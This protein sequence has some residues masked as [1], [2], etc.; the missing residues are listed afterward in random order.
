[1]ILVSVI[2]RSSFESSYLYESPEKHHSFEYH[3]EDP[4]WWTDTQSQIDCNK[5]PTSVISSSSKRLKA[6]FLRTMIMAKTARTPTPFH[7]YVIFLKCQWKMHYYLFSEDMAYIP[8]PGTGFYCN[9]AIHTYSS[10]CTIATGIDD[11]GTCVPVHVYIHVYTCTRVRTRIAILYRYWYNTITR[12]V[13]VYVHVYCTHVLQYS[14][15][16]YVPV[17]Q[18]RYT[19]TY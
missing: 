4:S 6:F 17:L 18:Y 3:L 2:F 16:Q 19:C 9:M 5:V 14:S 15:V 13:H 1:M 11:T 12:Y 10:T 8:V 7:R